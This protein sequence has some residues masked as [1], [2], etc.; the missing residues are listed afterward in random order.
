MKNVII[1]ILIVAMLVSSFVFEPVSDSVDILAGSTNPTYSTTI[2]LI[3]GVSEPG[4]S[5]YGD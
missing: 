5:S 1:I 4:N 2:D 3:A